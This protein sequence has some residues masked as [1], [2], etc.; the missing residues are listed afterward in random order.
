M[1]L[2][3]GRL[4]LGVLAAV[5]A[6]AQ[7]DVPTTEEAVRL[8]PMTVRGEFVPA[9]LGA[10]PDRLQWS[11]PPSLAGTAETMP[12]MALHHMGAAAAEPI[13]RGLGSDRVITTLDGLP[14]PNASPTR[15]DSAITLIAAGIPAGFQVFYTLPSVT[16]GPP[17]NAGY[18]ELSSSLPDKTNRTYFG[19]SWNTDRDGGDVLAAETVAHGAWTSRAALTAHRLSDY[20]SGD[21][22]VVPAADRNF[23]ASFQAEWQADSRHQLRFGALFSRQQLAVNSAL[24]LDTRN[25]DTT[26]FT[27]GYN[28][29]LSSE[30]RIETRAGVGIIRPH[31]DN[32]DR[33]APA[34]INA[35]GRTRSVAAGL[36]VRHQT[37]G[38]DEVILG[39]DATREER[40]LERKRP[41][42]VDLLWPDLRQDDAGLFAE[43]TRTLN[44][45]WKLR[46]G[47]R[48]D[49]AFSEA[50]A[51]DG[52]AFNR[53]IRSLYVAFNG[54]G[55]S[56]T[57]RRE[58]AGAANLLLNGRLGAEVTTMIG[59][60]FSRQPPG[61]S[62]RYRAFSDALGGGYEIGNP[63][64]NAEDK[65]ELDWNLRWHRGPFTVTAGVFGSELP[66]FL[67]RTRVGVT[68]PPPPPPPGSI[69]Y[70]YR[71][72]AAEF[73][74][75]ELE[76]L[77]QP[78]ADSWLRLSAAG[79]EGTDRN[80]HRRLPE[81]PPA[82]LALGLGHTWAAN[83]LQPWVELG[84]RAAAAQHN[85]APDDL[86]VFADT[87]AYALGNLRAGLTWRGMRVSLAVENLWDRQ[88]YDYLAPPAGP[89]PAGGTLRPSARIPGPGR[90]VI[91]TITHA[92]P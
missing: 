7:M 38:G 42:A 61:A 56:G 19:A 16:L 32:A 63:A 68:T 87:A 1:T 29:S 37:G 15:T 89:T 23:G 55:A 2:L 26:A 12:G 9:W 33:P 24:P 49:T 80:A 28:W 13:L 14:L 57:S 48:L 86:P 69:V 67:H 54:P 77:W 78:L 8:D 75:G 36:A 76:A 47:G 41:G 39:A 40:R 51:A 25:T 92:L 4:L 59:A 3:R 21:G 53:T 58:L 18:V 17:A 83:R 6:R 90:T 46:L 44:P 22:T 81:I 82:T 20:T 64:A 84:L 88:Y 85:P 62:E 65:Y 74:G 35:D 52:L 27:G 73:W 50:R 71:S 43:F 10:T 66:D 31:L 45:G 70:G 60:G 30:T 72:T 11:L 34:R 91:F 79:V 5:C